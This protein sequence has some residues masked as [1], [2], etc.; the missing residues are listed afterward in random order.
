M[1]LVDIQDLDRLSL[2]LIVA[3]EC[4]IINSKQAVEVLIEWWYVRSGLNVS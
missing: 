1:R 2:L 4:R 3:V